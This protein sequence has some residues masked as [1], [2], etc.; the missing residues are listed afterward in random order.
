VVGAGPAGLTSALAARRHLHN[1][2]GRRHGPRHHHDTDLGE[3]AVSDPM[4]TA[5]SISEPV[6]TFGP[7]RTLDGLD[8]TVNTGEVH[9]FPRMISG[10]G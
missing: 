6:K 3:E 1:L 5:I 8:V 2:E 4:S 9:G 10:R 7:T